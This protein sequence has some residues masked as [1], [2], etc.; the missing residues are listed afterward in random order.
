VTAPI[1][2]LVAGILLVRGL[3]LWSRN[4]SQAISPDWSSLADLTVWITA[5]CYVFH[6]LNLGLGGLTAIS[7]HNKQNTKLLRY[8]VDGNI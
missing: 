5:G 8:K 4:V 6:S 3:L 7:S 1:T 2:F